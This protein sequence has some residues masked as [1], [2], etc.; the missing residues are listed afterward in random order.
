M[1]TN[2]DDL[3]A[4]Y[5]AALAQARSEHSD[6]SPADQRTWAIG[7]FYERILADKKLTEGA[8]GVMAT[9]LSRLYE[10]EL[11]LV[12]VDAADGRDNALR[13]SFDA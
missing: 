8:V 7:A 5:A 3:V 4:A 2:P 10:R 1:P 11:V 12:P 6:A 9:L 13:R